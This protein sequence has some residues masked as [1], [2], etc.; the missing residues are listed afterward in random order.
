MNGMESGI[1]ADI[2]TSH[3][4]ATHVEMNLLSAFATNALNVISA[5]KWI[6]ARNVIAK[7]LSQMVKY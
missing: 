5:K 2:T 3:S 7:A 4:S 1:D 6:C